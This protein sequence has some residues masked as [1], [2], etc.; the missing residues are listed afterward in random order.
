M[1]GINKYGANGVNRDWISWHSNREHGTGVVS[2]V[3][4]DSACERGAN[5]VYGHITGGGV[6]I[7]LGQCVKELQEHSGHLVVDYQGVVDLGGV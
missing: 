5:R 1:H 4:G 6:D 7:A 2:R 3:N